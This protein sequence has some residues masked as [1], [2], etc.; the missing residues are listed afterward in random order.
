MAWRRAFA[1]VAKRCSF[2][3][4]TVGAG[5]SL[6][7][8]GIRI[9]RRAPGRPAA[10]CLPLCRPPAAGRRQAD[11]TALPFIHFRGQYALDRFSPGSGSLIARRTIAAPVSGPGF[12]PAGQ[13]IH[14]CYIIIVGLARAWHRHRTGP[15]ATGPGIIPPAYIY[16]YMNICCIFAGPAG[17]S[18]FSAFPGVC[19][20]GNYSRT[21]II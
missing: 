19:R 14:R 5:S 12:I 18:I 6:P 11:C 7:L 8:I 3:G 2:W 1:G 21:I 16:I 13:A 15:G 10:D 20:P 9:G 4:M 17:F